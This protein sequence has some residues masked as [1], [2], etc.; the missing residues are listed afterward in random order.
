MMKRGRQSLRWA[1][2]L[3][4]AWALWGGVD[5]PL[6]SQPEQVV[7]V[8]IKDFKFVTKQGTL[9]LGVPTVIRVKNEDSERHDFGSTMFEGIPTQVERDGV[10]VYG[11]GLG[12]V[13][14]DAKREAAI[15]FNMSRP[16]RHEFRCSIH[17]NMTGELLMLNVEAV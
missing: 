1:M 10:V 7:E 13:F 4:V 16:G 8:T 15:R 12:G 17:P 6:W 14:L 9:R 5:L 3:S 11:P 2:G